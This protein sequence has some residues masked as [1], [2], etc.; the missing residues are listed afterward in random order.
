MGKS[1]VSAVGKPDIAHH[2]CSIFWS[3]SKIAIA[4]ARTITV[5]SV[6]VQ[7]LIMLRQGRLLQRLQEQPRC[8]AA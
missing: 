8:Y 3:H 6:A 1:R 4:V 2:K 7:N 5:C